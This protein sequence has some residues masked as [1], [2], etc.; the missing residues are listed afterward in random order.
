MPTTTTQPK[1][2]EPSKPACV[3]A[4]GRFSTFG[5]SLWGQWGWVLS[6]FL[7]TFAGKLWLIHR[8]GTPLPFWDQWDGEGSDVYIPYFQHHLSWANFFQPHNEHR[9]VFTRLCDLILL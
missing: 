7:V 5:G 2:E 8:S 1:A 9:I 3:P 4:P 6:L